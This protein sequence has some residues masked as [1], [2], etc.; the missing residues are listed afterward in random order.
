MNTAKYTLDIPASDINI[1]KAIAEKFGW[2]AKKQ[3]IKKAWSALNKH[4]N[5]KEELT[6]SCQAN[7]H[8]T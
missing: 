2:I 8:G 3:S 5:Q 7:D 6:P 1:F 4:A